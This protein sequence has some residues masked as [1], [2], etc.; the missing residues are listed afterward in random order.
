MPGHLVYALD[1]SLAGAA[2]GVA[3]G[4]ERGVRILTEGGDRG[5]ANHDDQGQHH[6]VFNRGRTIFTLEEI[7]NRRNETI[8]HVGALY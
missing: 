5:D 3:N 4:R 2:D 1:S 6:G 8:Q 7:D